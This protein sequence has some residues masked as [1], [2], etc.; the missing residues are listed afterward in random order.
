[1][2]WNR[3]RVARPLSITVVCLLSLSLGK[4]LALGA[5]QPGLAVV[6]KIAGSVGFYT[7]DG[8]LKGEVK[9]GDFP[10]EAVLSPDGR[11]LYVSDNGVL[12][13]SED[14]AG[15]NT[16]SVVDVRAMKRVAVIDL[17][18]FRRPH[19]L[20]LEPRSGHLLA[21]TE[22]PSALVMID[23]AGRKVLRDFDIQGKAPHMVT[24]AAGGAWAFVS[25]V[26][27]NTIAALH[28]ETG[29]VSLIPALGRPQGGVLAPDGGRLY[30]VNGTGDAITIIDPRTQTAVG[31][32]PTGKGP[33]RIAITPDGK[34]LVYNLQGDLSI[35]FADVATGRQVATLPIEGRSLSLT[36]TRDGTR[37]FAGIQDQDKVLV[38]S[39]PRRAVQAVIHTP[40]GSGPDPAIPLE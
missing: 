5:D 24:L 23:V 16:I 2:Q 7:E 8:Q 15:G 10:H 22:R 34:T 3:H 30:I 29:R 17:G 33:G 4:A 1:M 20:A 19:G 13:M 12:W 9:V 25:N 36:M 27:S 11:W 31:T 6:E 37:A 38:I 18:P 35:G 40:K 39:V 28:V 26:D 32:I 21:T 14:G